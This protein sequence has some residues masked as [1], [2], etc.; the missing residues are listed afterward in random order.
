MIPLNLSM[1]FFMLESMEALL[2][3]EDFDEGQGAGTN[4]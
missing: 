1:S 2:S 3:R 4:A